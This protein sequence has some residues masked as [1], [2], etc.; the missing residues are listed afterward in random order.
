MTQHN[1]HRFEIEGILLLVVTVWGTNFVV[2]KLV[3]DVMHPHVI[4]VFRLLS[5][6][7]VLLIMHVRRQK[8]L[9]QNILQPL[10]DYPKE[11]VT[12]G[13]MGWFLY[14]IVF[15][16]GLNNT[17]AGTAALIM[18]SLPLW[19]ALISIGMNVEK[20]NSVGWIGIGVTM[21][22][23]AAVIL[24]G[25]GSV[26]ISTSFLFG[27]LMMLTAAMLWGLNTV[28]TRKLVHRVTPVGITF[29]GL[30]VALP[31][32]GLVSIPFWN[33]VDWGGVTWVIWLAIVFSGSLSTGLAIVAWN[34]AVKKVGASHTSAF[35]NLVPLVALLT[36]FLILNEQ[37]VFWQ[38]VGGAFTIAGLVIMR[39]GRAVG[40]TEKQ[41]EH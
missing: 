10:F 17:T 6:G 14:Q 22:G 18:A 16:I 34:Y 41:P 19:T 12:I 25:K 37:I 11:L 40:R 2:M 28:L 1:R 27:N 30:I 4:N 20:L 32:I 26:D 7:F 8:A 3:L 15:I 36:S 38:I 39:H 13:I 24:T 33:T 35:Q 29:I 21:I 31:L 23:T 9:G 5:A